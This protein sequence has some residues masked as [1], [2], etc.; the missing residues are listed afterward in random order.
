MVN[1][2]HNHIQ[3]DQKQMKI[4]L[5]IIVLQNYHA[6]STQQLTLDFHQFKAVSVVQP[7]GASMEL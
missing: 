7:N 6:C 1:L 2:D 5:N 3:T 4:S